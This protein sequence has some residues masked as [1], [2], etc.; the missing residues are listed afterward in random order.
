MPAQHQGSNA[1]RLEM[2]AFLSGAF[3][4]IQRITI[5][6]A[7]T[8]TVGASLLFGW[9]HGLASALGSLVGYVN[10]AWLHRGAEMM[11][12]RLMAPAAHAPSRFRLMLSF[13]G[14]Y[15][16]VI[17]SASVILNR[18]SSVLL[19]FTT[20]LFL[21]ILA[22]VCEGVFEAYVCIYK[23]RTQDKTGLH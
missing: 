7:V 12:E 3:G 9:R 18:F 4:R 13:T 10:L 5:V 19:S 17:T 6:L 8:T 2:D 14:R 23:S 20:A 21:P 15:A 22:A 11:I 1:N 16:F